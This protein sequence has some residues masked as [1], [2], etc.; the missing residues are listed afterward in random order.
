MVNLDD[1]AINCD[2]ITPKI[3]KFIQDTVKKTGLNG[4]IVNVSG[5][6]DSAVS[7]HLAV[8][9][10]GANR[11]TAITIP[12]RDVTPQG[13]IT[14]VMLH[15]KQLNLTCNTVEITPILHVMRDI[16]PGYDITDRITCGNIRSRLRMMIAYYHANI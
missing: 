3:Y 11:V 16:M 8:Q 12:E 14:D 1:L 7:V 9:A 2:E 4:V 13:D 15:C 5:G 6:I 10:L